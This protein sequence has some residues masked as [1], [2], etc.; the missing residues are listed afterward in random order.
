VSNRSRKSDQMIQFIPLGGMAEIGKNSNVIDTGED[1]ILI[2]CGVMFPDEEMHGVDLVIP[3]FSYVI[4]NLDRLRGIVLTHSHEDHVGALPYL[5]GQLGKK[6]PIFATSLTIGMVTGKLKERGV[7]YLADLNVIEP[8]TA[9]DFGMISINFI[10]VGHSIPDAVALE[11]KTPIGTFVHSGDFKLGHPGDPDHDALVAKLSRIGDRG[12]LALLSECVRVET[13]GRTPPESVVVKALEDAIGAASGRVIVSTFA[14]N[15]GRLEQIMAI[16]E[17]LGRK[18]AVAGRSLENNVRVA[19]ELGF[20][21]SASSVLVPLAET[22][23]MPP[24]QVVLMSTGSQGEPAAV[25]ARIA[26]NDHPQ[27]KITPGDTVI[28]SASPIPGNEESVAQT[29]DNLF[30]RGAR[31]IYRETNHDIHVSG[32]A[33]REELRELIQ[34]IRP[35]FCVPL[36]GE[37]RMMVHYRDLAI[38]E[39]IPFENVLMADN[40]DILEFTATSAKKNG[41]AQAG[42]VLVDGL[43]VGGVTKVVLRDRRRL[44]EDGILIASIVVDRETGE[45]I[46]GPDIVAR[47]FVEDGESTLFSDARER[48]KKALERAHSP[49]PEFG[50]MT[51]KIREVLGKMVY[52]ETRKRPMIIPLVTEV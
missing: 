14:S 36:H 22:R 20:M 50:F 48:I 9:V 4:N 13:P 45:L 37:Y 15:I 38:E 26:A 40:G 28:L 46:S 3:D 25:L 41:H 1:L 23:N 27:I 44:A 12:V 2:D 8:D 52:E 19:N 7:F 33:S 30:R 51:S 43:T 24:N 18:V 21:P 31:V 34:V 42:S 35:Q 29:I 11:I 47:G 32:H 49:E 17:R 5:L 10:G 6:T 16:A 39:G